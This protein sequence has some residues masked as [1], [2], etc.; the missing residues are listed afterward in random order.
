MSPC[1]KSK[2][3]WR[4]SAS[5]SLSSCSL[6]ILLLFLPL[7]AGTK[8]GSA[9]KQPAARK[10]CPGHV[11]SGKAAIVNEQMAS[12]AVTIKD[13]KAQNRALRKE[14]TEAKDNVNAKW[15]LIK[16]MKE[17]II[18]LTVA[19]NPEAAAMLGLFITMQEADLLTNEDGMINKDIRTSIGEF[20]VHTTRDG[21]SKLHNLDTMNDNLVAFKRCSGAS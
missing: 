8:N 9:K 4:S 14:L 19:D 11:R 15:H 6:T 5:P 17:E 10:I 3:P 20:F 1:S 21:Y 16:H 18:T 12:D 2:S 7:H 13:L